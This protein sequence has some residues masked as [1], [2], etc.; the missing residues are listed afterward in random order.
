MNDA[1]NWYLEVLKKYV[2]LEGRAQRQEYWYFILCNLVITVVLMGIDML[3]GQF[4]ELTGLGLLSGIYTMLVMLPG[5]SVTVRRLHDT[6]RSGWWA[7]LGII[8]LLGGLVLLVFM[9]LD[10][11][12]GPN[13]FG[14][15]PR[16]VAV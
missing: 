4:N 14:P 5:L 1:M 2:I 9:A 15:N 11:E 7:L 16:G 3:I 6:G 12:P 10:S 13:R 8:P